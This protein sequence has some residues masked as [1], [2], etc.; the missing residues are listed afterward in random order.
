MGLVFLVG[1]GAVLGLLA[2]IVMR[3]DDARGLAINVSIGIGGALFAGLVVH[4]W[5][6]GSSLLEGRYGVD[7]LLTALFGTIAVLL[8]A[9]LLRNRE[10][11]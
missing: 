5:L 7:G 9:N 8:A 11:R 6:T 1:L 4:P 3:A 2:S 10:V